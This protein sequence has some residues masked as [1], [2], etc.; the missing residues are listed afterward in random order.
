ML[1]M[2]TG[3]SH[4]HCLTS[5][6]PLCIFAIFA[7]C[8]QCVHASGISSIGVTVEVRENIVFVLAACWGWGRGRGRE[9]LGVSS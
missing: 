6:L 9:G 4:S 2:K 7:N 5:C 1:H 3:Y 8:S